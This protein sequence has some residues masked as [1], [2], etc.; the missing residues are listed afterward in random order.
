MLAPCD[1]DIDGFSDSP[2]VSSTRN[3]AI[4]DA[5]ASNICCCADVAA[6]ECGLFV[7][8][9]KVGV[10]RE[11]NNAGREKFRASR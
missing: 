6:E 8:I 1:G 2:F 9:S 7:L 3:E 10:M 5:V 4:C 11:R